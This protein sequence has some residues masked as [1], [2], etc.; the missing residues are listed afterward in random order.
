M[1]SHVRNSDRSRSGDGPVRIPERV[2][3]DNREG[4]NGHRADTWDIIALRRMVRKLRRIYEQE[5][6]VITV[7][8]GMSARQALTDIQIDKLRV[9]LTLVTEAKLR[10]RV[11]ELDI[12]LARLSSSAMN[13]T[14]AHE[15][16][17]GT[18]D[19]VQ[20][21][22]VMRTELM[23]AAHTFSADEW[24]VLD[25]VRAV[26]AKEGHRAA[27]I[28]GRNGLRAIGHKITVGSGV[29][30]EVPDDDMEDDDV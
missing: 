20:L 16:L 14:K 28:A 26:Q 19:D 5:L 7:L 22:A 24:A 29:V 6:K 4:I 1:E 21:Q 30:P 9:G 8:L 23:R 18:L 11:K 2:G 17:V 15:S 25:E 10:E 13:V 27:M 3:V 12:A